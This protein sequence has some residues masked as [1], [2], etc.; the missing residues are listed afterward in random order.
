MP[1]ARETINKIIMNLQQEQL[2]RR[3]GKWMEVGAQD[4]DEPGEFA[5]P[6]AC[7]MEEN[8]ADKIQRQGS[9]HGAISGPILRGF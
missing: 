8:T 1:R 2:F 3:H 9:D 4:D 5:N 7:N 6:V